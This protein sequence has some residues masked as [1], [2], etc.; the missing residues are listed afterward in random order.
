MLRAWK[1]A[2]VGAVCAALAG[3]AAAPAVADEAASAA[4]FSAKSLPARTLVQAELIL[5]GEFSGLADGDFGGAFY[6]AVVSYQ[7]H[8]GL[9]ADGVLTPAQEADLLQRAVRTYGLLG[10]RLEKDAAAG[11]DLPLPRG[12]PLSSSPAEG[13]TA[14]TSGADNGFAVTLQAIPEKEVPLKEIFARFTEGPDRLVIAT[15]LK[16]DRFRVAGSLGNTRDFYAAFITTNGVS[17]G[18]T[19]SWLPRLALLGPVAAAYLVSLMLSP[20]IGEADAFLAEAA[21][22]AKAAAPAPPTPPAPEAPPR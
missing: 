16:A 5:A 20:S 15:D 19:V 14:W 12:L 8:R 18:V 4:W 9:P 17:R 1:S 11:I 6:G 22:K 2:V 3:G 10:W 7:M 13:G 21:A